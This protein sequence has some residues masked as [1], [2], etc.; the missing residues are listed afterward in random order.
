[1]GIRCVCSQAECPEQTVSPGSA[2]VE[3]RRAAPLVRNNACALCRIASSAKRYL[4]PNCR[5]RFFNVIFKERTCATVKP[6]RLGHAGCTGGFLC[7]AVRHSL[8][9]RAKCTTCMRKDALPASLRRLRRFG[10]NKLPRARVQR[11]DTVSPRLVFCESLGILGRY[12]EI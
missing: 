5:V 11:A 10:Y 6:Q 12:Q 9:E 4:S 1:M 3:E 8:S 2:S 7:R